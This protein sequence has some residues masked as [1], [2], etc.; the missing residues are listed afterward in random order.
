M[1]D[2]SDRLANALN[3]FSG[4]EVRQ[5]TQLEDLITVDFLVEGS[6]L[7]QCGYFVSWLSPRLP[8]G[9]TLAI[10]YE[11]STSVVS[12]CSIELLEGL[13]DEFSEVISKLAEKHPHG[14]F[15]R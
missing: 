10:E 5:V 14:P 7:V 6:L 1:S 3:L 8:A 13:C 4:V 12:Q 9:A 15:R 2:P 11:S